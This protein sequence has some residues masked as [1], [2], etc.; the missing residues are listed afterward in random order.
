MEILVFQSKMRALLWIR[1][2]HDEVL[3]Q[4]NLWW[5]SP[6]R[7]RV[8]SVKSK[9]A[10]FFWRPPPFGWLKFNV[11]GIELEDRAG[12]GGVLRDMERVARAI[13]LGVVIAND[14]EEG[15][16]GAVK[17]ALEVFLAMNWK[18]NKSLFIEIGFE[19][20]VNPNSFAEIKIAM[21]KVGNVVF[22]L[23]EKKG[24]DMAFSLAMAGVNRLQMFKAW[25]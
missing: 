22:T 8:D 24:N 21:M 5:I 13:F 1:S 23:T 10:A 3:L 18:T 19:T 11:C 16:I 4:E 6:L 14:A 2:I 12:C 7:C 20:L 17:I 9:L 25:W 15:E